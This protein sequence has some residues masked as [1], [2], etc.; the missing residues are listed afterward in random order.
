MERQHYL[1]L[2]ASIS[3]KSLEIDDKYLSGLLALQ[4]YNFNTRY[5]GNAFNKDIY[6][7]LYSALKGFGYANT[8]LTGHNNPVQALITKSETP[9]I[10]SL[11]SDGAVI[12][13]ANENNEWKGKGFT[14]PKIG[15]DV[16]AAD[17]SPEGR[18]WV[19]GAKKQSGKQIDIYD[20]T[21]TSRK[22][23]GL[24]SEITKIDFVREG[25]GFY[26][27]CNSGNSIFYCDLNKADEVISSAEKITLMD[28]SP[29][30]S[31]LAGTTSDGNLYIWD[32]KKDIYLGR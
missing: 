12:G 6:N 26:A 10:M 22:I 13:W 32:V 24:N 20:L 31:K 18:L 16:Y 30:G 9:I 27:L 5:Q 19:I 15:Y 14:P 2:A 11:S 28:L 1:T 29:D 23:E 4:A 21:Y 8:N 25:K 17:V 3:L 7:G